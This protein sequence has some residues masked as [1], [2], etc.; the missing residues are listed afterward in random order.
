MWVC[1][2]C[3]AASPSTSLIVHA[4][5][6]THTP[7]MSSYWS[8]SW[9]NRTSAIE[10][11]A[12][13]IAA[14]TPQGAPAFAV[15]VTPVPGAAGKT[16]TS[17]VVRSHPTV[18]RT[19]RRSS[20]PVPAA[21]R[22][23]RHGLAA[24]KVTEPRVFASGVKAGTMCPGRYPPVSNIGFRPVHRVPIGRHRSTSRT[25]SVGI[26]SVDCRTMNRVSRRVMRAWVGMGPRFLPFADAATP[27]LPLSRLLRLSLFQVSVGMALV[28]LIGTL[29]RVMIV[30]LGVPASL[31]GIM[32]S[33]PL[34]FAPFR[35]LIGFRSDT[36]RSA[37]RLEAGAVH[38]P[39]RHGAVR[40]P[41]DHAVR[42]AGAVR[43]RQ[44]A[45]TRRSGSACSAPAVAFLLVGAGL[46]TTQTVG[47]ALAT[48]LAPTESQPKVVGLMYVML[49]FGMIASALA[50]GA[51][52]AHFSPGR[53]I[54]VIQA[55]AVATIVLNG[56]AL[57]KQEA[58]NA[59]PRLLQ[60]Q[61][62][63]PELPPVLGQLHAGRPGGAPPAGRRP[64]HDGVQHGGRAAGAL[65]R[66]GPASERRRH[67]QV[68]RD[69]GGRRPARLR[70]GVAR[71]QPRRRP[72]PHGGLRRAGRTARLR[73]G[74]RSP[75]RCHRRCCSRPELC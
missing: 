58:R 53:L 20:E 26:E 46:H 52:L 13:Q 12:P 16:E 25:R 42:P 50:F 56:V 72:V 28:L 67:D 69:A 36:H 64:R 45:A 73:L 41:G 51:L 23:A 32:I 30:E 33:L 2:F 17:F 14:A 11:N 39:R 44:C 1:H 48:D 4:C 49:L 22:P 38:V 47:L 34:I 66:P 68:D 6:M 35:A 27:D 19:W 70:L 31:V 9:R 21:R 74:D 40:R 57:W 24:V 55:A 15:T 29:N 65:W 61:Q 59:L 8:G 10:T 75:G 60:T 18:L 5:V 7:W 43:H 71:A 3:S 37:A 54:Q 63:Q 62:R